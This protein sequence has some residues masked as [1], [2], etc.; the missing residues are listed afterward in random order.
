MMAG[1]KIVEFPLTW[2]TRH[3]LV[4]FDEP[5]FSRGFMARP[6]AAFF[7]TF[8]KKANFVFLSPL[9]TLTP[10]SIRRLHS[11]LKQHV[12]LLCPPVD[13]DAD[14]ADPAQHHR[15]EAQR[16]VH[17][18][19]E[20]KGEQ[21]QR[22]VAVLAH[23][24][25]VVGLVDPVDPERSDDKPAQHEAV[26]EGLGGRLPQPFQLLLLAAAHPRRQVQ[27]LFEDAEAAADE[28]IHRDVLALGAVVQ[29]DRAEHDHAH[30]DDDRD[31]EDDGAA[32]IFKKHL[33]TLITKIVWLNKYSGQP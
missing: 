4:E 32:D 23:G 20:P 8:K 28:Q 7:V 6:N 22:L 17:R 9:A 25:V 19:D 31:A 3:S 15:H 24:R 13:G 18:S 27:Q 16:H 12:Q 2:P 1:T 5:Y 10:R 33:I 21:V 26:D 30:R 29:V 14:D 11:H